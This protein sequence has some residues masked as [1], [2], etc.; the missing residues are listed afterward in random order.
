MRSVTGGTAA[1]IPGM[2]SLIDGVSVREIVGPT[3]E[4]PR[5]DPRSKRQGF[6]A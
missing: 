3:R 1:T 2:V 6:H 4:H 5:T